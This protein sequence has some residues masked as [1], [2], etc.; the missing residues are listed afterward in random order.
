M[1]SFAQFLIV[2]IASGGL[3]LFFQTKS[4]IQLTQITQLPDPVAAAEPVAP[5]K[6]VNPN[7][8]IEPQKQL[9]NPPAV[10]KAV[11]ATGWTAGS[12]KGMDR[13]IALIKKTE[14]NAVIIDI[15]DY[16]GHMSYAT[17]LDLLKTNGAEKEIKI[18]KPNALIKRLHDEGIYVIARQTIFQDPILSLSRPEL[19]LQS[20]TT[21][22]QWKDH[23]GIMW[24]D[25]AAKDVWSYNVDIAKDAL[26]RG[27]DEINL[28]YIR[29]ASDGNLDDIK[30]PFWDEKTLKRYVIR[31]F[32]KYFRQALPEAKLSADLFGLVTLNYGDVGIGQNLDDAF[33][34]F[35][36]ISP[37]VYPSHYQKGFD[38]YA[39]PAAHP[40][41]VVYKSMLEANKRLDKY[42]AAAA[43]S[44]STEKYLVKKPQLRP[45]LQ[46]FDLGAEYTAPM[47]RAQIDATYAAEGLC[48]ATATSTKSYDCPDGTKGIGGWMLWDP[49]NVYTAGALENIEVATNIN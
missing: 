45:W 4:N 47:V 11:Y 13:L 39:N 3:F 33:H 2:V 41:E 30:F 8:D 5:E 35:D 37:M 12:T 20:L 34:Y 19:S 32:W 22:K 31:D 40:F 10:I 29:F 49:R 1:K 38:G 17:E 16:S 15:K 36:A 43:V 24:L 46:D 27:F 18:V 44:T 25:P 21:G 48:G 23:K 6:P 28:D 26:A 9:E 42:I 14:I 7:A